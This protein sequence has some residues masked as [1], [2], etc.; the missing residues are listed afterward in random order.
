MKRKNLRRKIRDALRT[1]DGFRPDSDMIRQAMNHMFEYNI[2]YDKAI[3]RIGRC[4][5]EDAMPLVEEWISGQIGENPEKI[6]DYQVYVFQDDRLWAVLEC[7][8]IS[9]GCSLAQTEQRCGTFKL[10]TIMFGCVAEPVVEDDRVQVV[11][12]EPEAAEQE[13]EQESE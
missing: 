2:F 1:A 8:G 9:I 12:T 13:P 7:E 4:R 10:T 3:H 11:W 5:H 6:R